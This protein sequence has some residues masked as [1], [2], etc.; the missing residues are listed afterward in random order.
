[1]E[2]KGRIII[3]KKD[4]EMTWVHI[5]AK[6]RRAGRRDI[7]SLTLAPGSSIEFHYQEISIDRWSKHCYDVELLKERLGA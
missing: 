5:H 2:H 3:A 6:K 1:M 7:V 4:D